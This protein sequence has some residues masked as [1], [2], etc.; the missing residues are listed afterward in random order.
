MPGLASPCRRS[1][2][3]SRAAIRRFSCRPS[4]PSP[5]SRAAGASKAKGRGLRNG[6]IVFQ[7]AASIALIICTVAVRSQLRFIRS[8]DMGYERDQIVVL[9]PRGGMRTNLEA[10][11]T[12]LRRNPV[13]SQCRDVIRPSRQ[14]QLEHKRQLAG[15]GR[16]PRKS[17]FMF[18]TPTMISSI[19][20]DLSSP[21]AGTSPAIFHPTRTAR[22]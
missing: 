14:G 8:L 20:S 3:R 2:A 9:S 6:L 1:S 16:N 4:G 13:G 19:Y 11:R 5:P 12:E 18:S 15:Q 21:E 17:R 22:F 10:F 7:F